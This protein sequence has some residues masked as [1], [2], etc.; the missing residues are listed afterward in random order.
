MTSGPAAPAQLPP[1]GVVGLDPAWSRL[2]TAPDH[3]GVDCTWHLLDSGVVEPRLTLLCVHGNPSWS[4]L[5]RELVA[6]APH[7]VRVIAVDQLDMGFSERTG[8]QRRLAD[9]VADLVAL[10]DALDIDGPVVTV[11][12]DWGGPIS[13]GWAL[14][15]HRRAPASLH[16]VVLTNTAVH[17]PAGSPAPALIRATRAR[18][19]LRTATVNTT[20]FLRGAIELS[21]PRLAPE[22]R[23]G[24]LAPY[25][26]RHRREA[27][28]AFVADVP[29]DASHPSGETLDAIA[30]GLADLAETPVLL[31]WGPSDPVF[32]DRYLHDLEHRLPHA[33]VHRFVGAGHFV[34]EQ[35]DV[36]G[37]VLAWI[38]APSKGRGRAPAAAPE[39]A[40]LW[41]EL[42]R[43]R[44]SE[45]IAV[46]ELGGDEVRGID[47]ARLRQR[48][49]AF[50]TGMVDSGVGRGD[51]VALMIPP[52]IDLTVAL[53]ACW[54]IG[55]V[56]VLV[57][58]GLGPRNMSRALASAAP[59]HLVGVTRALSAARVLR[60][61]GRRIAV[62]EMSPWARSALRI[63]STMTEL[64]DRA[65]GGPE[66]EPPDPSD[67]AVVVF[68]SGST[69]PSKGV[70]YRHDQLRAQRD[71]LR[72]LYSIGPA[73]RLVA[74][75]A[76]FALF[77]PAL[78]ITS[79][80]PHM[81]VARPGT[82]TATALGDAVAEIDATLVFASP[83]AL[84]NVV[85]TAWELHGAELAGVRL[86]L[87]AGAPVNPG[88]LR[89]TLELLPNADMHTPYGMTEVLPVADISLHEL[90][91]ATGG[92]GVCVGRPS[93][94]VT[95]AVSALDAQGMAVGA[96]SEVAGSLGEVLI[97]AEHAKDRYDRL[98]FT[99]HRSSR[100]EGWHRSGDV[101]EL[102]HDGRLWIGGRLAH[103]VLTDRGPVVPVSVELAAETTESVHRAAAVGIGPAGTQVIA[104]AVESHDAPRRGRLASSEL[105]RAVR[106]AVR[107]AL[108][109]PVA[110]VLEVAALP[111]DRRH[112]SKIDRARVTR[113]AGAILA[114][115]R[116]TR[117]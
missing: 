60:W 2:V 11:G 73:D 21:R 71:Q 8:C 18:G 12:H 113:W 107:Q 41:S 64:E 26:T 62:D 103:V 14:H 28:A 43:L 44:S 9:R 81:H 17:Q 55:A 98:W 111:V 82:L 23:A 88:L 50:G 30:A 35:A 93:P 96:P 110:A 77:G 67:D 117:L 42:D 102:D 87:S 92:R 53:Y 69:G 75:F 36:V 4:F 3:R 72:D 70:V 1:P 95:V 19:V 116:W 33:Q 31:L 56:A 104:I 10:T 24:F 86:V 66:P 37:A 106:T 46:A 114:G 51:R 91:D 5:W 16:G 20:A 27:I 78:G 94:E 85:R 74:A 49:M 83:A 52:G 48:V 99:E 61:P 6:A 105:T 101:G 97:R 112:E 115:Q 32:S 79:A 25:T 34:S 58:S 76:P 63:D 54:R 68:T 47:F 29:L 39:R 59:Q 22:V 90:T 100:P 84:T 109:L 45:L 108:D 80:V 89:Q 40:P 65:A 57:D 38:D 13:L 15:S 7:D